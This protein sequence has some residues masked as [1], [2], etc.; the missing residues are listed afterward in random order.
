MWTRY[1]QDIIQRDCARVF[2]S[3]AQVWFLRLR[4]RQVECSKCAHRIGVGW[5]QHIWNDIVKNDADF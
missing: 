2:F 1:P 3:S 5:T 4:K